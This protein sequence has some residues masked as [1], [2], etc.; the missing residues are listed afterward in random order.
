MSPFR[1]CKIDR[2][3]LLINAKSRFIPAGKAGDTA[4]SNGVVAIYKGRHDFRL[5]AWEATSLCFNVGKPEAD[6]PSLYYDETSGEHLLIF[7]CQSERDYLRR[8]VGPTGAIEGS[9]D[10]QGE[11][12]EARIPNLERLLRE[13]PLA[14][15][16]LETRK[17]E[18]AAKTSY[19]NRIVP[20]LGGLLLGFDTRDGEP[21]LSGNSGQG[22]IKAVCSDF[23]DFIALA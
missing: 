18:A 17:I 6:C 9:T 16:R 19:A 13:P 4:G 20:E 12:W 11:T 5:D 14:P 7:S 15:V 23:S 22:G 10:E 2:A 8:K 3:F 1:R 21:C